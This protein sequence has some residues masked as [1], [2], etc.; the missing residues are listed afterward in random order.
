MHKNL[1]IYLELTKYKYKII[2][3]KDQKEFFNSGQLGKVWKEE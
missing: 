2:F 1:I 3:I